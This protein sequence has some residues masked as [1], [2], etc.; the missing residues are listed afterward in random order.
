MIVSV[1]ATTAIEARIPM[2]VTTTKSSINVNPPERIPRCRACL[3][4]VFMARSFEGMC[5]AIVLPSKKRLQGGDVR[6]VTLW[7]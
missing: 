5:Y 7:C 1:K 6:A 4:S 2:I 3:V